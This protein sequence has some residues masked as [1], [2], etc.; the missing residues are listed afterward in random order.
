MTLVREWYYLDTKGKCY[1]PMPEQRLAEMVRGYS[2]DPDDVEHFLFRCLGSS[3]WI[4]LCAFL[5][6][7]DSAVGEQEFSA[8]YFDNPDEKREPLLYPVSRK[9]FLIMSVCT[10]GIYYFFWVFKTWS[11]LRAIDIRCDKWYDPLLFTMLDL[12]FPESIITLRVYLAEYS[13]S[14]A[15]PISSTALITTTR[16]AL[17]ALGLCA[18]FPPLRIFI[19]FPLLIPVAY[20][21]IIENINNINA[22]RTPECVPDNHFSVFNII[23]IAVC[24]TIIISIIGSSL[25]YFLRLL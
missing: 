12:F 14:D 16:G 7:A 2:L 21:P 25:N 22:K 18:L 24:L 5:R 3:K 13:S 4:D 23:L 1:G 11:Y 15:L 19:V 9:K 20:L 6:I 10:F 17:L 8:N